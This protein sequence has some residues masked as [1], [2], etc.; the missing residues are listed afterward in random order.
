MVSHSAEVKIKRT[1]NRELNM[2]AR[3]HHMT[4]YFL[5][6]PQ[7]LDSSEDIPLLSKRVTSCFNKKLKISICVS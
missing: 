3:I 2:V 7:G 5:Q 1:L 4:K 6:L